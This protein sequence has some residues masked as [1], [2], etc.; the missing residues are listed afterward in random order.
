MH[1]A[2]DQPGKMRHVDHQIGADL[3]GDRAKPGEIDDP[4]IGAAAGDDQLWPMRLGQPLDLVEIDARVLAAHAISDRIEPFARQVGPRA[5][6]QVAA[7]GKRHAEDRVARAQ[8]RQEDGLVGLRARMRLDIGKSAAEEPLGA[9]D[10]QLLGDI[11]KL[12]AAVIAPPRIALGVF[13]GQHRA[14]RLE[15]RARDDVLAGD[16]LDL[17]LLARKFGGDCRGQFGIGSRSAATITVRF[18]RR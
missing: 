1:A 13:I 11:D 17:R 16:Q 3:V 18:T 12:A 4:R 14:L 5:V 6:R 9:I 7:G 2:G 10:R 15:H 8:Q